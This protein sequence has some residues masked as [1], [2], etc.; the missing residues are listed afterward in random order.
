M[1]DGTKAHWIGS[2]TIFVWLQSTDQQSGG[3]YSLPAEK[4]H[5]RLAYTVVQHARA[6]GKD[7]G[8]LF[9]S[10]TLAPQAPYP[11]QLQQG[12]ET[13]RYTLEQLGHQPSNI[14]IGGDSAG[15]NL[16]LGVFSHILHP[17]PTIPALK[18]SAPLKGAVIFAPWASFATDTP[19]FKANKNK[20]CLTAFLGETWSATFVGKAAR[21]NYNEPIRT[22]VEWWR[23]LKDVV[24]EIFVVGGADEL[25]VDSIKEMARKLETAHPQTTTLIA[26]REFHCQPIQS[27][28]GPAEGQQ[29]DGIREWVTS[30]L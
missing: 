17:H 29:A 10:Y 11:R 30:R 20:D 12:V 14:M 16:A 4:G 2:S 25:L 13:L 26:T 15:G 18:L 27:I 8:V 21:D 23:G 28:M 1:A 9:P 3:G 6:S 24:K 5:Y 22:D 7:L 19:S